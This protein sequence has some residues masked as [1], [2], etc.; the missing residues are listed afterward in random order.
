MLS[1]ERN[2]YG[3]FKLQQMILTPSDAIYKHM[4]HWVDCVA[5][6]IGRHCQNKVFFRGSVPCDILFIGEA[7]TCSDD[8]LGRPFTGEDAEP[9][10]EMVMQIL[11]MCASKGQ[12]PNWCVTNAISCIL[13]EARKPSLTELQNCS[14]RLQEFVELCNP[15]LIA[16]MGNTADKAANLITATKVI[17]PYCDFRKIRHPA[18]MLKQHDPGLEIRKAVL[19][20]TSILVRL[21]EQADAKSQSR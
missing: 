12:H 19:H 13:D 7:P 18:W 16:I 14:L 2:A 6:R 4:D 15:K 9:F 3:H 8:T 10:D 11:D 17:V 1:H 5:C 20:L 21:M